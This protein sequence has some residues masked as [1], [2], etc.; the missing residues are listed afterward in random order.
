[1]VPLEHDPICLFHFCKHPRY[2]DEIQP[3]AFGDIPHRGVAFLQRK[4]DQMLMV[5]PFQ[6]KRQYGR[7]SLLIPLPTV[8]IAVHNQ[9]NGL[10]C[11]PPQGLAFGGQLCRGQL[12]LKQMGIK[13]ALG[14]DGIDNIPDD[15]CKSLALCRRAPCQMESL[16]SDAGEVQEFPSKLDLLLCLNITILVMAIADVSA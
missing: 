5:F 9:G 13:T 10:A 2:P 14:L 11:Q 7:Q 16:P 1:M 8:Y 15:L 6:R 12:Q 3:G 4:V